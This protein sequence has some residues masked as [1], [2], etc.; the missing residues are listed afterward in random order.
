MRRKDTAMRCTLLNLAGRI[1][2]EEGVE[3]IH[4]RRLASEAN[5]ATGTLYNYFENKQEVLLALTEAYWENALEEMRAAITAERF[6]EQ[7]AQIITFLRNK[8]NDCAGILMKSIHEDAAAGKS[9]MSAMQQVL[10]DAL[11]ERLNKDE[12]ISTEVWTDSFTKDAFADFTLANII[13]LLQQKE[14]GTEILRN[15]IEKILY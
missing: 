14:T 6:S 8:M 11:M 9:R 12:A 13:L 15:I 1:E 2:C 3:A 10:R 5:I 4:M 7:V